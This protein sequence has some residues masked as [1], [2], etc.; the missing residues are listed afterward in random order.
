[1]QEEWPLEKGGRQPSELPG[2][3]SEGG[4]PE[5]QV[6]ASQHDYY[7]MRKQVTDLNIY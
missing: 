2:F 7:V 4:L 1:M 6:I 5:L 3:L